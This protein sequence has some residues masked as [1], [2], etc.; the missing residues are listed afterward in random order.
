MVLGT[1]WLLAGS[2]GSANRYSGADQYGWRPL[3]PSSPFGSTNRCISC[4][5]LDPLHSHPVEV[6]PSMAVPAE[7]PLEMGR[8]TCLT[9]HLDGGPAA[10]A[11]SSQLHD[12][13]IRSADS[14]SLCAQCHTSVAATPQAMHPLALGKAHL[15]SQSRTGS[16]SLASQG[17]DAETRTCMG[18]HDGM[19]AREGEAGMGFAADTSRDHPIGV[20]Y[21]DSRMARGLPRSD[22]PLKPIIGVDPRI[23]L[24]DGQIGCG[25]CHSLYSGQ[26]K[27]L[28]MSNLGSKLCLSCHRA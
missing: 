9:C 6:A 15:K 18:C 28:V 21:A 2:E 26:K 7:L 19:I 14:R 12:G 11:R 25:S 16:V 27:L 17:L 1:V 5:R 10:H 22:V 24:F 23:R 8:I 4:H 20:A 13:M 3:A